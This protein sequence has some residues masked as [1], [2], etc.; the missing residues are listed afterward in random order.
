VWSPRARLERTLPADAYVQNVALAPDGARLAARLWEGEIEVWSWPG[1][2][3]LASGKVER[4][5]RGLAFMP[6]GLLVAGDDA[7]LT[8]WGEGVPG[9]DPARFVPRFETEVEGT[10]P[11]SALDWDRL[12]L[13]AVEAAV[14][15]IP[16]LRHLGAASTHDVELIDDS[17]GWHGPEDRET[18]AFDGGCWRSWSPS[19]AR[20]AGWIVPTSA[21]A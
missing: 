6:D 1:G 11:P 19:S 17:D 16:W 15:T 18:A 3:R 20:S 7:A 10:A 4:M 5:A 9:P 13:E 12:S 2:E 14:P 8:T 21:S